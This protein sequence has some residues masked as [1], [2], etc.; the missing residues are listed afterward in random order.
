M[1]VCVCV[2]IYIY[3]YIYLFI[4]FFW[5]EGCF[6]FGCLLSPS[7]VCAGSYPHAGVWTVSVA[8]EIEAMGRAS[9]QCLDA[10]PLTVVRTCEEVAQAAHGCRPWEMAVTLR[11]VQVAPRLFGRGSSWV[12]VFPRKCEQQRVAFGSSAFFCIDP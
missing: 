5:C 10:G 11:R 8:R 12:C 9:S 2:Y 7:L 3:I 4:F 1:C 6:W